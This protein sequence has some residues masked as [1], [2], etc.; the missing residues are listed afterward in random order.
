M[1]NHRIIVL[2]TDTEVGKTWVTTALVRGLRARGRRAWLHKP[3]ACGD[4]DGVST[5]D[6]RTL[7]GLCGDGQEAATVCPR[8]F[9]EACSPHLAAQAVGVRVTLADLRAGVPDP[10]ATDL[11]VETAGGLLAPLTHD[12]LTNA[13]LAVA[14]GWPAIVVTRPHLGTLNHTQLTVNEARRRGI[15]LLGLVLNHHA[16]VDAGLAVR[17]AGSELAAL[18]GLPLLVESPHGHDP[19]AALAVAVLAAHTLRP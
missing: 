17:S 13:D 11:V 6:G 18:T 2:G 14:L 10:P 8:E 5:A 7:R 3:V 15:R 1:T 9:P 4:W 19:A 16:P 12:R